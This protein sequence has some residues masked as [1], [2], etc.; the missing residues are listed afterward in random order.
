[1]VAVALANKMARIAWAFL[2][3]GDTYRVPCACGSGVRSLAIG[4]LGCVCAFMNCRGDDD[5]DA[6]RS[7]PS[8]GKPALGR[9]DS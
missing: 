5:V 3:K 6:K 9:R 2:A 4:G 8:I 7:R 1:V